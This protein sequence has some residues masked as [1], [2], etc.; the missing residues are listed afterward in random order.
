MNEQKMLTPEEFAKI[1]RA[2]QL[3][4]Q[5]YGDEKDPLDALIR[6][7]EE[8]GSDRRDADAYRRY[9]RQVDDAVNGSNAILDRWREQESRLKE[10]VPDID[11]KELMKNDEFR[12]M[13]V[14]GMGLDAAYY[15]MKY[16]ETKKRRPIAQNGKSANKS[17]GAYSDILS[18]SDS[19]FMKSI[20]NMMNK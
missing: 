1:N 20:R 19:D 8:D 2:A 18:M 11:L 6:A 10:M 13:L 5:R 7:L 12:R 15:A 4:A 17:P 9:R 16:G 14:S 3:A